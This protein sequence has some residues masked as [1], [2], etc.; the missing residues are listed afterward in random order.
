[1]A[2]LHL[3][4]GR[5]G[6]VGQDASMDG[7]LLGLVTVYLPTGVGRVGLVST[8][9]DKEAAPQHFSSHVADAR[10]IQGWEPKAPM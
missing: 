1:M 2:D 6:G 9:T 4:A 5:V 7:S 8:F 10:Q 3:L